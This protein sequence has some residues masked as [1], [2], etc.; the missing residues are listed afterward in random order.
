MLFVDKFAEFLLEEYAL[1]YYAT[2][3][4]LRFYVL[5]PKTLQKY[6]FFAIYANKNREKCIFCRILSGATDKALTER[7]G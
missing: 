7:A 1:R 2:K 3:Y 6:C 4:F 5:E